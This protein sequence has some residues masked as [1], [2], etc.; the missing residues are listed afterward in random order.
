MR[1]LHKVREV[2]MVSLFT[3]TGIHEAIDHTFFARAHITFPSAERLLLIDVASFKSSLLLS[4]PDFD[5]RSDPYNDIK[6][7]LH[8]RATNMR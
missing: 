1:R 3:P 6:S 4:L 5:K 7:V 8:M 2:D